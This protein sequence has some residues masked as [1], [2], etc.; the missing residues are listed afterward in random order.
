MISRK[1]IS[2]VIDVTSNEYPDNFILKYLFLKR[3]SLRNNSIFKV[4]FQDNKIGCQDIAYLYIDWINKTH[5]SDCSSTQ[6]KSIRYL[7]FFT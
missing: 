6:Q 5:A 7:F 3:D 4:F 2:C 1:V